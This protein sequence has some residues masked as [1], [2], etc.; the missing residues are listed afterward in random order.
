MKK[1]E[2]CSKHDMLVSEMLHAVSD[3]ALSF[4]VG[5]LV[6][7][8]VS[9]PAEDMEPLRGRNS[10]VRWPNFLAPRRSRIVGRLLL[11][12]CNVCYILW[13]WGICRGCTTRGFRNAGLLADASIW[14]MT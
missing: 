3:D 9:H 5:M 8:V 7:R 4:L 11:F 1:G 6:F 13:Y 10:F 12:R 14:P 2:T